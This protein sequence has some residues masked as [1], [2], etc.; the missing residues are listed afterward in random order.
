M[1]DTVDVDGWP[2]GAKDGALDAVTVARPSPSSAR[3]DEKLWVAI[4]LDAVS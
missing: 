3:D 4:T 2:D 1:Y